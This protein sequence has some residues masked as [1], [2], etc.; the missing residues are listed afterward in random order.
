[1]TAVAPPA[2]A[3]EALNLFETGPGTPAGKYLRSFWQPVRLSADLPRGRAQPIAVMGEQF[4]LYRGTGGQAVVTQPGCAHRQT[5]LSVG[6][7]EED[8]IRC[9]FHG[10]LFG[11]D[12]QCQE[13]PGQSPGLVERMKIRT[14]PTH[15]EYGVIFAY[16]GQGEAPHF[17]DID[18]FSKKHGRNM[19]SAL[20]RDTGTYRRNCN[21]YINVENVLDL[22]HVPY[23]HRMS[24]DPNITEVG[25]SPDVGAIRGIT[26]ERFDFGVRATELDSGRVPTVMTVMLPNAMH[27]IVDQRD[28]FLE[29]VAWRVPINDECHMSFQISTLHTDEEGKK[30]YEE[31]KSRKMDLISKYPSTEVCAEQILRGD[32]TLFDFHDHP[33]LVNIEDH[34]AQMGMQFITDPSKE[35]L[36]Q[37]DKA[38]L[39]LRRMFMSRLGD[40]V[41]GAPTVDSDW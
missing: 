20:V 31:Y 33:D 16:F 37:S 32:K 8:S 13:A 29:Q 17:P 9:I 19:M 41:G 40:F 34:V 3:V 25:F 6:N 1:M 23:T 14:Y 30:R 36:A 15:E 35:N 26:V 22:A 21:Y 7:V 28:G 10:W 4:T 24:S 38:V 27:L 2:P 11:P 39:Q 5:L 12:G 18:G